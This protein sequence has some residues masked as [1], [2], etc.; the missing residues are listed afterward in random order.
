MACEQP[1]LQEEQILLYAPPLAPLSRPSAAAPIYKYLF[2]KRHPQISP[3]QDN[4]E[5]LSTS[6]SA[7]CLSLLICTRFGYCPQL[8]CTKCPKD[9]KQK[10]KWGA[11][12]SH[13]KRRYGKVTHEMIFFSNYINSLGIQQYSKKKCQHVS[14]KLM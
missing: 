3:N 5:R 9:L 14:K 4:G 7:K 10:Q 11:Y 6:S 2:S 1:I 8:F 13:G 12:S